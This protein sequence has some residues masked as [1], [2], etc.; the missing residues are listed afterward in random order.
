MKRIT[1]VIFTLMFF[2]F[3]SAG[4][5]STQKVVVMK[6]DSAVA[7][8]S[9]G[10]IEVE[11]DVPRVSLKRGFQHLGHWMSF[12]LYDAPSQQEY[13]QGILDKRLVELAKKSYGADA[14]IRA[15][16]WPDL[17][18]DTFPKWKIYAKGEMIEYKRFAS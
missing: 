8:R 17:A 9:L 15:Q 12:G 2:A 4:C 14:V 18:S 1:A 5:S 16:Y 11:R 10:Q 6:G 7:Y 3:A 13:L